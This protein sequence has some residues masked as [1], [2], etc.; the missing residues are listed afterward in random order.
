MFQ[1]PKLPIAKA[2]AIFI[3]LACCRGPVLHRLGNV[4][5]IARRLLPRYA[6]THLLASRSNHRHR[7]FSSMGLRATT[8]S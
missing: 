8:L 7:S 1:I 2:M 4:G 3:V 6:D 5:V